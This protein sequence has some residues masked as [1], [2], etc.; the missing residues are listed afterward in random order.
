MIHLEKGCVVVYVLAC[1][2]VRESACV[3]V[4]VCCVTTLLTKGQCVN[5]KLSLKYD[6]VLRL[7]K[8]FR[9]FS[10]FPAA[11][12]IFDSTRSKQFSHFCL[13]PSAKDL[14]IT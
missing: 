13:R 5:V 8:S 7:N 1:E 10:N 14:G 2:R 12:F 4:C 9:G 6:A 11:T 3:R